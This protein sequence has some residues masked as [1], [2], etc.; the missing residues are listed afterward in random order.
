MMTPYDTLY[1]VFLPFGTYG[2]SYFIFNMQT[3]GKGERKKE[4]GKARKTFAIRLEKGPRRK[5]FSRSRPTRSRRMVLSPS[6]FLP[7]YAA[8][9]DLSDTL[10]MPPPSRLLLLAVVPIQRR[11]STPLPGESFPDSNGNQGTPPVKHKVHL[12]LRYVS[13]IL[14][15]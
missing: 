11:V 14:I 4:S 2:S 15:D 8:R 3:R 9:R 13:T 7:F 6:T 5:T 10:R 1:R 12:S